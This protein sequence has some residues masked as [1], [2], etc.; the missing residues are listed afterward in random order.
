VKSFGLDMS[1]HVGTCIN[2]LVYI[3]AELHFHKLSLIDVASAGVDENLEIDATDVDGE[4]DIEADHEVLL[5]DNRIKN[6]LLQLSKVRSM[7]FLRLSEI[8]SQFRDFFLVEDGKIGNIERLTCGLWPYV[9]PLLEALPSS[10][11][12]SSKAPSV[13][14]THSFVCSSIVVEI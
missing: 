5:H 11:S 2:L 6:T 13:A 14:E 4:D 8:I 12:S 1:H 3:I 9:L 7:C 10:V